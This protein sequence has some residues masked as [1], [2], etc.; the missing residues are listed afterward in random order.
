M[1]VVRRFARDP[2]GVWD[3]YGSSTR[4]RVRPFA[5]LTNLSGTSYQE[6]PGVAMPGRAIVGGV[7]VIVFRRQ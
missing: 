5:Q 2:Y 7:E 3:V 4:G 1:G 6:I